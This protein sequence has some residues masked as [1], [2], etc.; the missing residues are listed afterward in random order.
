MTLSPVRTGCPSSLECFQN[1]NFRR[2]SHPCLHS[3]WQAATPGKASSFHPNK[4]RGEETESTLIRAH[5]LSKLAL[6]PAPGQSLCRPR[7]SRLE[8]PR[9]PHTAP[10]PPIRVRPPCRVATPPL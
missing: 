6:Q 5:W 7:E 3:L 1:K 9:L 8:S 4:G 2:G 10:S